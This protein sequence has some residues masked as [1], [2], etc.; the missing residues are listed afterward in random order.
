MFPELS[1]SKSSALH[2]HGSCGLWGRD[3]AAGGQSR[4]SASGGCH[5]GRGEGCQPSLVF[6]KRSSLGAGTSKAFDAI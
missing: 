4:G 5:T 3:P 2:T 1:L 6:S